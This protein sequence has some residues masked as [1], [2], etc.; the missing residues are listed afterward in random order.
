MRIECWSL[1]NGPIASPYVPPECQDQ[2]LTGIV[3]DSLN[4]DDGTRITTSTIVRVAFDV[5]QIQ[6]KNNVYNLG[7]IDPAYAKWIRDTGFKL[8]HLKLEEFE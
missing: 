6:T 4:F 5:K 3:Y 1:V 8:K 7:K 2:R